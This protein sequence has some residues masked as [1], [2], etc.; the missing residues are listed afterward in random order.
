[1]RHDNARPRAVRRHAS[2]IV[3]LLVISGLAAFGGPP[4]SAEQ[5]GSEVRRVATASIAAGDSHTC[6]LLTD[7][8]VR[9]WGYNYF[10]QLG[11]TTNTG[12]T[13][14]NPTPQP[15]VNLGARAVAIAAG[16]HHS[17][18]LLATG[19]VRCWGYNWYGQLGSATNNGTGNP[20]PS[21]QPA[22]NLGERAVAVTAGTSHS[23]ALLATGAVRCWGYNDAGQLGSTTNN[24]TENP[25]PTP[26]PAV[27]LGERAVAITAGTEHTCALL[28]DGTVRCWGYNYL[29]QLGSATN[30]GTFNANPSPQ[31]AVNLG[32]RAVALTAAGA[33]SCAL[34][35]TGTVRCWGSNRNGQL[36][37]ATNTGTFNANPS[38]QPGVN[39]GAR[40]VAL[41]AAGAHS[42]ALLAN[43]I[44]RCWG[45]NHYGQLGSTTGDANPTP[46]PA[47][48]L[49]PLG[50][51]AVAVAGGSSYTCATLTT[52]AVRCWGN[53]RYGQLGSTVN[54]GS[55]VA[56]PAPTATAIGSV[57]VLAP[58]NL[59]LQRKPKRDRKPPY[60][61]RVR[62]QVTGP[63]VADPAT[64]GG[65]VK[66]VVKKGKKKILQKT[67]PV[68]DTCTY[69]KTLKITTKKLRRKG[70]TVHGKTKIRIIANYQG[71][72]NLTR[73]KASKLAFIG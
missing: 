8:T 17:C 9:C 1:M 28:T 48:T 6:A 71:T 27:N 10:G 41:T 43:G 33:H 13:N 3:L 45:Y 49:T 70:I 2:L 18:A 51:S 5:A 16:A 23:C 25:N 69:A 11:S 39:L 55:H 40:A 21:P 50:A 31:P 54:S 42:C 26:Q 20:T 37:S 38:P 56:N 64:C 12:T 57:R 24:G 19:T 63:F 29:G 68:T 66:L 61:F 73:S 58:T 44:V 67:A 14:P 22:V 65:T 32:A 52:G 15:A 53:N 34:L 60:V 47:V 72:T 30:T 62:G 36:G 35:A 4:A 7:G 46:Q 59:A